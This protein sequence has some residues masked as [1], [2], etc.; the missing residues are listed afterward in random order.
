[1][2]IPK[3]TLE[4]NSMQYLYLAIS[5]VFTG[6]AYYLIYKFINKSWIEQGVGFCMAVA[7][8]TLFLAI[9]GE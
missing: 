5:G 9:M 4:N 8:V 1:M 7:I 2:K 3:P 6:S